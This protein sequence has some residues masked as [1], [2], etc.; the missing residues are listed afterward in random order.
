LVNLI[1]EARNLHA[2]GLARKRD[3]R[4]RRTSKYF[5]SIRLEGRWRATVALELERRHVFPEP[6][7]PNRAIDDW[8]QELAELLGGE[9]ESVA[10]EK[11]RAAGN[12]EGL[13]WRMFGSPARRAFEAAHRCR[14]RDEPAELIL[15]FLERKCP[16][17]L[18][19]EAWILR[20][21]GN[22]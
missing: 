4:L 15:G 3:R 2:E 20:P 18:I 21:G 12:A 5:A 11:F 7:V 16:I 17:G 1:T 22:P 6:H 9:S 13:S 19:A 14:H 10:V 8:R